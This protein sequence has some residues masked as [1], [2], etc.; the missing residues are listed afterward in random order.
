M[1]AKD[2]KLCVSPLSGT[3]YISKISKKEPH[4]MTNDRI[5]VP[6]EEFIAAL[7]EWVENEMKNGY[8]SITCNKKVILEITKPKK[9]QPVNNKNDA[10]KPE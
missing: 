1:S 2:Y 9:K 4:I 3:V 10:N 6:K 8:L 5:V 7:V